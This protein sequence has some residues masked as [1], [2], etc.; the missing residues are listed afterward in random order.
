MLMN[1]LNQMSGGNVVGRK[2][3]PL[4]GGYYPV[5]RPKDGLIDWDR[6]YGNEVVDLVRALTRPYPGAFS[7]Y[8]KKKVMIWRASCL[9]ENIRG[10]PGRVYFRR[11]HG[12]AVM[13]R[14][15]CIIL[16]EVQEDGRD[17]VSANDFFINLGGDFLTI[18]GLL[19]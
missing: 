11:P 15:R 19:A 18:R 12:V 1:T 10:M 16:E 4:K 13:C 5:R 8:A 3:D 2:Q 17:P 6:M 7:F 14:D 9:A